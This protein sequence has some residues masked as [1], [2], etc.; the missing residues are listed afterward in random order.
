[1]RA[2]RKDQKELMDLREPQE[3]MVA[4]EPLDHKEDEVS[5]EDL[6]MLDDQEPEDQQELLELSAESDFQYV[7][8][9]FVF[10]KFFI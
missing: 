4:P 6:E 5:K 1:M 8:A 2:E 9:F 10:I 3:T 7:I